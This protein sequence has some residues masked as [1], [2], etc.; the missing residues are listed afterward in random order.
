MPDPADKQ[1]V[2]VCEHGALRSRI[3]AAYFNAAAPVGWSAVSAGVTP[4]DAV[5]PRL[6][7]LMAG[8]GVEEFV[9]AAPP[10]HLSSASASRVAAIDIDVS[11]VDMWRTDPTTA[12]E[13]LRDDIRDRVARLVAEVA[14][15]PAL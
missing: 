11:G 14:G 1:I 8:T 7:P 2:F 5:S 6:E 9:D 4:Q 15:T 10:R 3:A 12:D 13:G